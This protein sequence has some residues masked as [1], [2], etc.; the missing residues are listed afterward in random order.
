MMYNPNFT[1][2]PGFASPMQGFGGGG[3]G[4]GGPQMMH[5]FGPPM[6]WGQ[7][8]QQAAPENPDVGQLPQM[9]T[10]LD[11][12][13]TRAAAGTGDQTKLQGRIDSLQGRV[14]DARQAR[15]QGNAQPAGG[16]QPEPGMGQNF[17]QYLMG[18]PQMG[19]AAMWGGGRPQG[20]DGMQQ[21]FGMNPYQMGGMQNW[22]QPMNGG[23]NPQQG[24]SGQMP[25]GANRPGMQ[26]RQD[27]R[28]ARQGGPE[29]AQAPNPG[30]QPV[31]PQQGTPNQTG[32]PQNY[33]EAGMFDT[34]FGQLVPSSTG[35][36]NVYKKNGS[37]GNDLYYYDPSAGWKH[38]SAQE[39]QGYNNPASFYQ[40]PNQYAGAA[41]ARQSQY[42]M[43]NG[44]WQQMPGS[45]TNA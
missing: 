21:G 1:G 45:G 2:W 25:Q 15:R 44:M 19:G 8:P 4:G 41:G 39:Y 13:R 10:Q 16:A 17:A 12:M 3:W 35:N 31:A 9:K 11:R 43:R 42:A 34:P 14:R 29:A 6:G 5:G 7:A 36:G 30:A 20:Y 37:D 23:Y 18:G 33:Y 24:M 40:D 26:Y 22:M 28:Q 38:M 32:V 27:R